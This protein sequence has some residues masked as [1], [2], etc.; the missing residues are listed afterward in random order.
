MFILGMNLYPMPESFFA[1][2][3]YNTNSNEMEFGFAFE[4]GRRRAL[5]TSLGTATCCKLLPA[6]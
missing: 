4:A 5:S 2:V 6:G 3:N 1:E